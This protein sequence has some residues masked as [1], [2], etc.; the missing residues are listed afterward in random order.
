MNLDIH[1]IQP[2]EFLRVA[3]SGEIDLAQSKRL[4]LTLA[5]LNEP[6]SNRDILLDCRAATTSLT[7]TGITVLVGLMSDH[8]NSF[9]DRLAI[10]T[11]PGSR[12][13]VAEFMELYAV[14]RGFHVA[15][16]DSFEAAAIGLATTIDVTP[17]DD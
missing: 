6:P 17:E 14:N 10:L 11:Q 4:L 13:E 12:H 2:K 1:I 16:F 7:F 3:P 9:R 15:A 5:S 8:R